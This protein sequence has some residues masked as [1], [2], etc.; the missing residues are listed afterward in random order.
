MNIGNDGQWLLKRL[1]DGSAP[2]G[3]KDLPAMQILKTL[4]AQQFREERWQMVYQD[5]KK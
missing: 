1:E 4:W 5:L 2:A 3:L